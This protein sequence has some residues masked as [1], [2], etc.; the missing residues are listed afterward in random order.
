[1]SLTE[2]PAA[3]VKKGRHH[4]RSVGETQTAPSALAGRRQPVAPHYLAAMPGA[5]QDGWTL[6]RKWSKL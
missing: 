4:I 1:M 3:L 6:G 2:A 5:P